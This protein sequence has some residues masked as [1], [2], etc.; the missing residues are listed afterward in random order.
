M[1]DIRA[2]VFDVN[3]TLVDILTDENDEAVHR[4]V[5]HLLTYQGIDVR[6]GRVRDLYHAYL[7]QQRAASGEERQL[8]AWPEKLTLGESLP[9]MPLWLGS[10]ICVA[11]DLD[12]T[13]RTTCDDLRIR[14]AG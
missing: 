13:Y 2:I 4:A 10:D 6:R 5:G 1:D 11:L 7:D 9:Q 14:A 8:H 3:G 12:V